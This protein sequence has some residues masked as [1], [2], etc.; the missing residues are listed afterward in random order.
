[1][2]LGGKMGSEEWVWEKLGP[3]GSRNKELIKYILKH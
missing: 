1:M 2:K 3:G